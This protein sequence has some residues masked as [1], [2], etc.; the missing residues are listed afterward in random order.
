MKVDVTCPQCKNVALSRLRK[1]T[2][3][4]VVFTCKSCKAELK[5]DRLFSTVNLV[6]IIIF[7]PNLKLYS[8]PLIHWIAWPAMITGCALHLAR[9]P[10]RV[11][12]PGPNHAKYH[13]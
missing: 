4:G 7:M 9:V 6:P 10:L 3:P 8:G 2:I 1:V 5:I 12:N 11:V 13:S